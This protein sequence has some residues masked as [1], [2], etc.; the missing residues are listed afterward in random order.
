M[1]PD[2]SISSPSA[3][4][5]GPA[6]FYVGLCE[7]YKANPPGDSWDGVVRIVQK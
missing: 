2:A 1:C 5:D 7:Q 4:D 3:Q 6:R